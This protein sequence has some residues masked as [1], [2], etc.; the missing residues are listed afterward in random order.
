V[1]K[2]QGTGINGDSINIFINL[3]KQDNNTINNNITSLFNLIFQGKI[4][5]AAC[6]FFTD[7]YLFCLHKDQNDLS[8]LR[9]I[10]IPTAIQQIRASHIAITLKD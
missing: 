3:V 6:K 2:H 1:A 4:P 5:P 8:T 7:T 9:P 10:G